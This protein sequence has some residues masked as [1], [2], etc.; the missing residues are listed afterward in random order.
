MLSTTI[1]HTNSPAR[2]QTHELK[3][4]SEA[5]NM[6]TSSTP[7]A[8]P[9]RLR[10]PQVHD[11][12]THE[13][14]GPPTKKNE[15]PGHRRRGI[16]DRGKTGRRGL[17]PVLSVLL[18]LY[19]RIDCLNYVH[20]TVRKKMNSACSMLTDRTAYINLVRPTGLSTV[21]P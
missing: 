10:A 13:K 1:M 3:K 18:G 15:G 9:A 21:L 20:M 6:W 14:V 19:H 11:L 16:D 2:V 12:R 4:R 8:T 7:R 5:K 17:F